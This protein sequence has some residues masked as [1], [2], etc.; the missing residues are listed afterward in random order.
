MIQAVIFL[1]TIFLPSAALA[2][3][4]ESYCVGVRGNGEAEPAHLGAL[5][6]MVEEYG[7]PKA[8]AGGSSATITM[9]FT[10]S[11]RS[12]AK[13]EKEQDSEKKRKLQALMLKSMPEFM[14]AM[15]KDAKIADGF[16]MIQTF[17]GRDPEQIKKAVG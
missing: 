9:F 16:G 6:R 13:V 14:A 17:G 10:E 12:N 1:A 11:I 5:S 7:M 2:G 4:C 8:M 15:T 3:S